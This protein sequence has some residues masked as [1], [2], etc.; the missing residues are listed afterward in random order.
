MRGGGL[1]IIYLL[2]G[3]FVAGSKDYFENLAALEPLLSAIL[4]IVLWPLLLIG[5]DTHVNF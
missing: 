5:I 4:A 1:T 2:V 3:A